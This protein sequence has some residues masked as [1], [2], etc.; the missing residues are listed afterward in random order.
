MTDLGFAGILDHKMYK[1]KQKQKTG[2]FSQ[3]RLS[4]SLLKD[5]ISFVS[6]LKQ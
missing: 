5:D 4:C 1:T 2:S 6:L 3:E